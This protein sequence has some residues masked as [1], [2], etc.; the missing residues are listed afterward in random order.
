MAEKS[1][2]HNSHTIFGLAESKLHAATRLFMDFV[3]KEHALQL[4]CAVFVV[5]ARTIDM[6]DLHVE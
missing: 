6:V 1:A 2:K 5:G 4:C 3:V